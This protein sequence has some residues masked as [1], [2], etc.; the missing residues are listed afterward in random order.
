MGR[1]S[2]PTLQNGHARRTLG[3]PRLTS[4][5]EETGR[6]SVAP[7]HARD[8]LERM[9]AAAVAGSM[10]DAA[11][12]AAARALPRTAAPVRVLA[13]GKAAH[14][15]AAAAVRALADTGRTVA[16]GVIVAP[17]AAPPPH[18]ALAAL[19]GDHPVPGARSLAAAAALGHA[20]G[21]VRADDQ[22][23][24][25]LS[26]GASSL[27]AAPV[28][29]IAADELAWLYER[30][31][32]SGADI[33]AMNGVRKRFARWSGGRLALALHPAPVHCLVVSDVLGDDLAAIASG[34]CAPDPLTSVDVVARLCDL[35]LWAELPESFRHLLA[36]IATGRLPETPKA[37]DAAFGRVTHD[38]IVSNA[39]A[40]RSA[41][42]R[43]RTFG[44]AHVRVEA[45]P[46]AGEAADCGRRMAQALLADAAHAGDRPCGVV[47]G[48]E[49]TVTLGAQAAGARGGRMQ[50]LALAAAQLLHDAGLAAARVTLLAAGTDG[51]DGPTD[52]AGAVVDGATWRDITRA[53]RDP[54][55]DLAAHRSYPALDSVGALLRPGLTGT[56]V[57][58]VVIGLVGPRG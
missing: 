44:V 53:G 12:A 13:M 50:E 14:G 31:L 7:F 27:V 47:W 52:A 46:F 22:V 19:A 56:N 30:L 26:G 43:G 57:M 42:A 45:T 34:P 18:P 4:P 35:G 17:A 36:G 5:P 8:L 15:M 16:G 21:A 41:A 48:G 40:V 24:V 6:R 39:A 38:V 3:R 20:V 58:D 25:L 37:S 51:R 11:T 49:P 29:G 33:A 2:V 54:A 55:A 10:P 23:L 1:M 28:D 9:Y 32:G